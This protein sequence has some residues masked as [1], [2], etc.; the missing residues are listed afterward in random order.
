MYTKSVQ[1]RGI[2]IKMDEMY[3]TTLHFFLCV[4][5]YVFREKKMQL[6]FHLFFMIFNYIYYMYLIA[7]NFAIFFLY[8][9]YFLL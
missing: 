7:L 2:L 9:R 8:N 5:C 3:Y 4:C 1:I 6:F